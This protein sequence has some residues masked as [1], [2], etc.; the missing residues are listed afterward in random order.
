M[1]TNSCPTPAPRVL[2]GQIKAQ[3]REAYLGG[4]I[5]ATGWWYYFPVAF[6]LKTPVTLLLL[7]TGGLLVVV[8]RWR[9]LL[10]TPLFILLPPLV[11]VG[12]SMTQKLNIGLRHILPVYPLLLMLGAVAIAWL[13]RRGWRS[14][15]LAAIGLTAL[16]AGSS[17]PSPLAFFNVFAGGPSHG[18]EYLVDSN[19]DWD[20]T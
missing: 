10:E 18:S 13:L 1:R 12:I 3:A 5:S 16:E 14:L 4:Q 7:M 19:L 8:A 6:L 11:I 17:Y 20:K 15:V 2:L 9:K